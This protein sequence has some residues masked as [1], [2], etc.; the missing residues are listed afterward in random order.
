[1]SERT[2]PPALDR[3]ERAQGRTVLYPAEIFLRRENTE[4]CNNKTEDEGAPVTLHPM[5]KKLRRLASAAASAWAEWEFSE[6]MTLVRAVG[7]AALWQLDHLRC[8]YFPLW[9]RHGGYPGLQSGYVS[10]ELWDYGYV[11]A[12][13]TW[14]IEDGPSAFPRQ[15]TEIHCNR[16]TKE[17]ISARRSRPARGV[18][19]PLGPIA[20]HAFRQ[21]MRREYGNPLR[22]SCLRLH[23][24]AVAANS[25]RGRGDSPRLPAFIIATVDK[26]AGLP[27]LAEAGAFFGH[28]D[29]EDQ[30]G[31]YGPADPSGSG[32][33]LCQ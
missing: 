3:A 14:V 17:C 30:W 1:M 28:V 7:R 12:A 25:Y 19:C 33:R 15:T 2:H 32:T 13:G 21:P 22:K 23:R 8:R 27:W 4:V 26:F 10:S 18:P 5:G 16:E 6:I 31:F 24:S 20:L 29:R 11:S 9:I